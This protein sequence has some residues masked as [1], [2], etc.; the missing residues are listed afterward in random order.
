MGAGDEYSIIRCTRSHVVAW[1][2]GIAG[3]D[4]RSDRGLRNGVV[5]GKQAVSRIGNSRCIVSGET[6]G[7]T[8]IAGALLPAA[9]AWLGFRLDPGCTGDASAVV[10]R[11][12]GD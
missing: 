9:G 5:H 12:P 4:A 8:H 1:R 6:A 11:L 2:I 10:H 7:A 3:R